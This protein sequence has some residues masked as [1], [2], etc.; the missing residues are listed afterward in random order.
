M[1]KVHRSLSAVV[2]YIDGKGKCKVVTV[3]TIKV[4]PTLVATAKLGGRFTQA[5]ALAEYRKA[6]GRFTTL[7]GAKIA[8]DMGLVA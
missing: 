4:G 1:V 5:Q 7:E 6:P 3:A 8:R 2:A